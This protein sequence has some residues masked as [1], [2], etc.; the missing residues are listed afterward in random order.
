MFVR[1]LLVLILVAILQ[2]GLLRSVKAEMKFDF[3]ITDDG[4]RILFV[5][6]RFDYDDNLVAFTNAVTSNRPDV[7]TFD[8]GGGNPSAAMRYGRRIRALG[9]DTVQVRQF[10][11]MSACALAFMG[12][13]NRT[14]EPG[15]IGVHQTY[16][17]TQ[18]ELNGANA[19]AAIQSH[20]A[21]VIAFMT[22]MGV[23]P[24]ILQLSLSVGS[25]DIRFLT[26]R[27]MER[28]GV[29]GSAEIDLSSSVT[30]YAGI[31]AREPGLRP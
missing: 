16:F 5:I 11:C 10:D 14:A 6:G 9:L 25:D 21:E 18:N 4:S 28:Y 12:G 30:R 29:I 23:S 15:S 13:V 27:E 1:P 19:V 7:V 31:P 2:I 20:T 26:G 3:A 8:S 24:V 22:E 17:E